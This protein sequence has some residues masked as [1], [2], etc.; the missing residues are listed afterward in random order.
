MYQ[1]PGQEAHSLWSCQVYARCTHVVRMR[2]TCTLSVSYVIALSVEVYPSASTY[3]RSAMPGYHVRVAYAPC[4]VDHALWRVY[5]GYGTHHGEAATSTVCIVSQASQDLRD[6][7]VWV[8]DGMYSMGVMLNDWVYYGRVQDVFRNATMRDPKS[9]HVVA[10][11]GGRCTELYA[12]GNHSGCVDVYA[13]MSVQRPL[14]R[15]C[16]YELL[17]IHD[18]VDFWRSRTIRFWGR[19]THDDWH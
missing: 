6:Y 16:R 8:T 7:T 5:P 10:L 9:K 13:R 15:Y 14:N 12:Y 3:L 11:L 19:E 1:L 4:V 18:P 17:D 2:H